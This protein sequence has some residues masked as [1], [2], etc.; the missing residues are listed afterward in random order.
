MKKIMI[1][2]ANFTNKGAQ[3]MLFITVD[4]LR[5]RI[6]D[7]EI[8]YA[9][10]EEIEENTF[11][12]KEVFYSE[13]S[14]RIALHNKR[15]Y[16][17]AKCI[18]KDLIKLIIGRHKNL[19]RFMELDRII[20]Q[21]DL[22]VD[23]SGFNLGVKWSTEIHESYLNN[24]RLAK[25]YN[26]PVFIMPQSFGPFHYSSDKVNLIDEMKELLPYPRRIYAREEEGYE[27]MKGEIGLQNV[28]LSTDLVLQNSGIDI[29]NIYCSEIN[30]D[31]PKLDIINAVGIVPNMQCFNHGDKLANMCLY[32]EI[33][34]H[35]IEKGS[36]IYLFAHSSEDFK[37]CREI[38]GMFQNH[39][40]VLLLEKDFTC[41]EYEKF[42]TNFKY[43]VCSRYHG[44]VH[45]Y[46]RGVPCIA[47]G[48][49]VKYIE[50]A[51][52]LNQGRYAFNIADEKVDNQEI[53]SRIDELDAQVS[54]ESQVIQS[55]LAEIQKNNC[56]EAISEWVRNG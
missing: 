36:I 20:K 30:L 5:K 14:K 25:K 19:W 12:F 37:I 2:G 47:L 9:G 17:I 45:A 43:I 38:K 44:I 49:A 33:V 41:L 6:P 39:P 24:I 54:H 52:Q 35:L 53:I 55:K 23:I 22:M 56:F 28:I 46:R 3:S 27:M 29:K 1:V 51:N 10:T 42:V 34:G 40:N 11:T 4:E 8:Y 16:F 15:G 50:L 13:N 21:I 18:V 7:C 32:K 31:V 48:W 26:I